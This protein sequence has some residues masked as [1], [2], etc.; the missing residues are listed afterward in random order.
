MNQ[1]TDIQVVECSRLHSEE[2][3][4]GNNENFASWINNLTDL[5]HINPGDKI[6]V[7]GAMVSERGAGQGSSIEIKGVELGMKKTFNYV[8]V[9]SYNASDHLPTGYQN[10]DCNL[11]SSEINIRDDTLNFTTQYYQTANAKN[12]IFLPRRYWYDKDATRV[13]Q[14]TAS[15]DTAGG[16]SRYYFMN[17]EDPF[18]FKN[19]FFIRDLG[20][21]EVRT[22]KPRNDNS[23]Y[24]IMMRDKS[25]FTAS[26]AQGNLGGFINSVAGIDQYNTELG[27]SRDP[28]NCVY[29]TY[30]ELKSLKLPAGFNSPEF[31]S[32]ELT[33]QLQH[34]TKEKIWKQSYTSASTPANSVPTPVSFYRT[35]ETETYKAFNVANQFRSIHTVGNPH[36]EDYGVIEDAFNQYFNSSGAASVNSSGYDYLSQYHVIGCKRPELYETG[37]QLNRKF[38]AQFTTELTGI[39]GCE[40]KFQWLNNTDL[41]TLNIAYNEENVNAFKSFFDSQLLYPEIFDYFKETNNDYHDGDN[42][43]NSRWIHMNRWNNA[44]MTYTD[45]PSEAMLG[46]SYYSSRTFTHY[47]RVHSALLPIYYDNNPEYNQFYPRVLNEPSRYWSYGL[48]GHDDL[49]YLQLRSTPNNGVLSPLWNELLQDSGDTSIEAGRKCGFD[50]HFNAP[51]MSYLLPYS[52][53]SPVLSAYQTQDWGDYSVKPI[54]AWE[55]L[56]SLYLDGAKYVNKLYLGADAPS[57]EYNGTNF[58]LSGLH[59]SMNVPNDNRVSNPNI[60]SSPEVSTG[61]GS[62]IYTINPKEYLNDWTPERTPYIIDNPAIGST[63][64]PQLNSNYEPWVIYDSLCGIFIGDFNLTEDEWSGTLW[65]LLGFT[66]DQ[67]NNT[68]N[69]RLTKVTDDTLSLSLLTT[70]AEVDKADSKVYVQN[71]WG[72]PLYSNMMPIVSRIYKGHADKTTLLVYYPPIEQKTQS[73]KIVADKLPTRMIR[74]YYTIRSNILQQAQFIGGKKNN[75]SMPIVGIVDKI[76]GDGDFY[77][78]SESS[79]VFTATRPLT[80]ASIACSIHDPDGSYARCSEQSTVLFKIEKPIN[81]TFNVVEELLQDEQQKK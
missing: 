61:A 33:S 43:N 4:S 74:G 70:N 6:S 23:R 32:S 1:L 48:I 21:S 56:T 68:E 73:I 54:D 51:G 40:L 15:D 57:L 60:T 13:E 69:T 64:I 28:E 53:Y 34:I 80:L 41:I 3:L 38:T 16:I 45:T 7:H 50:L 36:V 81:L 19:E 65:D 77:F 30:K 14:W 76:N 25:Y 27:R 12:Y 17:E 2:A 39:F 20:E 44:S 11:S 55:K 9:N 62:V 10:I 35:I 8:V 22:F 18:S 46:D 24:T 42:I 52:G 78:Q 79:L 58:Q 47:N 66:Y 72:I 37:R 5:L 29:R 67:F 71:S 59:T 63:G 75:T 49:G 31:I 26:A